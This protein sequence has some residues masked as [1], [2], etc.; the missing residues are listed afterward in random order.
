MAYSGDWLTPQKRTEL[1]L[2]ENAF[3]ASPGG[4]GGVTGSQGGNPLLRGLRS[5]T[6]NTA[7]KDTVYGTAAPGSSKQMIGRNPQGNIFQYKPNDQGQPESTFRQDLGR[8]S[9]RL[10]GGITKFG[11]GAE[12]VSYLEPTMDK[13]TMGEYPGYVQPEVDQA[14]ISELAEIGMGAPMGRL[15][16]GLNSA[17]IEARYSDN[18]TIR[19]LSRKSALE[20]YGSGIADVRLGA[21]RTAMS[22]YA[23]EFQADVTRAGTEYASGV[24]RTNAQFQA[25][26]NE[27]FKTMKSTSKRVPG[28]P[29]DNLGTSSIK[30]PFV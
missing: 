23:P 25:D 17:L 22:E 16:R 19:D 27:Y 1:G 10:S 30:R 6:T 4:G 28:S 14:R 13:P 3:V 7:N 15:K 29:T 8:D 9:A 2:S 21:H 18:P 24:N 5:S 26:I 11:S 12:N 20:G